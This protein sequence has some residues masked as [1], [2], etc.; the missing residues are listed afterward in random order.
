[1]GGGKITFDA[2]AKV[3]HVFGTSIGFNQAHH[4]TTAKMIKVEYPGY[5]VTAEKTG[6]I[7]FKDALS[8]LAETIQYQRKSCNFLLKI[9]LSIYR[10]L[11]RIVTLYH[12]R[13]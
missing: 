12:R 6:N 11:R 7:N 1:M 9:N 8:S 10:T 5:K 13:H 4:L 3:I 2:Q